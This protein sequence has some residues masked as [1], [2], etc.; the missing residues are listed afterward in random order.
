MSGVSSDH[1]KVHKGYWIGSISQITLSKKMADCAKLSSAD[2]FN[3]KQSSS[4]IMFHPN[5][6]TTGRYSADSVLRLT[7]LLGKALRKT[8]ICKAFREVGISLR[9]PVTEEANESKRVTSI[10]EFMSPLYATT[11]NFSIVSKFLIT[12]SF[13]W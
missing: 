8:C 6:D 13:F 7:Q 9:F 2:N 3:V 1:F 5:S 12:V 4:G 11:M 10:V